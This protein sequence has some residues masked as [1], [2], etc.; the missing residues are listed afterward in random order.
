[1]LIAIKLSLKLLILSGLLRKAQTLH[2]QYSIFT[3]WF[4]NKT[5]LEFKTLVSKNKQIK[6]EELFLKLPIF[7]KQVVAD[8]VELV[9]LHSWDG[10]EVVI[11]GVHESEDV[12]QNCF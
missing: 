1:M 8:W 2:M 9:R 6:F 7:W 4:V 11:N 5:Y 12:G 10:G 3:N